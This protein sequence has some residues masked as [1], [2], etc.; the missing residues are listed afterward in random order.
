MKNK[1]KE[2]YIPHTA[3]LLDIEKSRDGEDFDI[4]AHIPELLQTIGNLKLEK[5]DLKSK[6]SSEKAIAMLNKVI[7]KLTTYKNTAA[8]LRQ[9]LESE[10]SLPKKH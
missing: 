5:I 1:N 7:D 9:I 4:E 10:D 2:K 6:D 3:Q 8:T